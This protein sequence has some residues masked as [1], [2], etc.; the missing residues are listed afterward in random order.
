M[1]GK[2]VEESKTGI[3]TFHSIIV[4]E[5]NLDMNFCHLQTMAQYIVN[6]AL[7]WLAIDGSWCT[8]PMWLQLGTM[9][10]DMKRAR[11]DKRSYYDM[12]KCDDAANLE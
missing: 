12:D 6:A 3:V 10:V 1:R 8:T 11:V 2:R 4:R 9:R 7:G 5:E